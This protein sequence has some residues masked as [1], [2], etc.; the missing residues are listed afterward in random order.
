MRSDRSLSELSTALN[1]LYPG[2]ERKVGK[3][4]AMTFYRG[5]SSYD[6]SAGDHRTGQIAAVADTLETLV[7]NLDIDNE[8]KSLSEA[9]RE[10][11]EAIG[12]MPSY[13]ANAYLGEDALLPDLHTAVVRTRLVGNN[14]QEIGTGIMTRVQSLNTVKG[15]ST[16]AIYERE[17]KSVQKYLRSLAGEQP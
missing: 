7:E 12:A 6:G 17:F 4:F 8:Q 10:A 5:L 3:L 14:F 11:R 9:S 1:N 15:D 16:H 13:P 2:S